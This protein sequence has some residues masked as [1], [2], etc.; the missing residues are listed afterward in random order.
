[1][2]MTLIDPEEIRKTYEAVFGRRPDENASPKQ[3]LEDIAKRGETY[4]TG[5]WNMAV[6]LEVDSE[7][8]ERHLDLVP[9]AV[10]RMQAH[11]QGHHARENTLVAAIR[12]LSVCFKSGGFFSLMQ[13]TSAIE[14]T[15]EETFLVQS[16]VYVEPEKTAQGEEDDDPHGGMDGTE[17]MSLLNA[18][19]DILHGWQELVVEA[20]QCDFGAI[21]TALNI[22]TVIAESKPPHADEIDAHLPQPALRF[23]AE[24]P[25]RLLEHIEDVLPH[26]L[27]LGRANGGG[28]Y[29]AGST[30]GEQG[31][32][33]RVQ[34]KGR[35][36]GSWHDFAINQ[37][38]RDLLGLWLAVR[39]LP[40][41]PLGLQQAVIQ[42]THHFGWK[43]DPE[44]DG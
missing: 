6:T 13:T 24:I 20:Q 10:A 17:T 44:T 37:S 28:E 9:R 29:R 30:D 19:L 7:L 31:N 38:G 26:L 8:L 11:H 42:I 4:R 43:F 22:A 36:A 5:W 2:A 3:M 16:A 34:M 39:G 41:T 25:A 1:M 18:K 32:S 33:L 40:Q 35:W 12:N 27:P 15:P 21:L 23:I 14:Q